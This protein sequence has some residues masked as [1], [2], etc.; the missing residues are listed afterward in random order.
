MGFL[1]SIF[2]LSF[3]IVVH[4]FGH[5]IMARKTG[6][7]VEKFS[8]GFGNK[9]FSFK[10]RDTEYQICA[11]PLGGYVKLAGDNQEEFSGKPDEYLSKSIFQRAKIVFS[12]PI[13]N[14]ILA[15]LLFWLV[16]FLGFPHLST[17]VGE[18]I[19]DF[20]AERA[21]ILVGDIITRVDGKEVKTFGELQ[22]IIYKKEGVAKLTILRGNSQI[23]IVAGIQRKEIQDLLGKKRMVGVIGI[24]PAED[25]VFLRYGFLE[26]FFLSTKT[27]FRFTNIT[28]KAIGNIITGSLSI[29]ES[30]TGPLGIFYI[31]TKAAKYGITSVLHLM[32]VLNLSL[33]IFNILPFPLLDG[34]HLLFLGIEKIRKRRISLK[35]EEMIN[36]AGLTLIIFLAIF[37][38]Y[39]D[40]VKFGV[41]ERF[42]GFFK[43]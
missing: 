2:V 10:K 13:L 8:L 39:N 36:R 34:G 19:K 22:E 26:S 15:F 24:R 3:L 37:V 12:G 16:F 14:Y 38:L 28:F 23:E 7:K 4:E 30:I 9:L 32:A 18:V 29:R 17:K 20:P 40:L 42:L 27:L 6:V 1:I 33:A 41:W 5:F 43:K 21:Q 31:T 11:I 35:T 25:F